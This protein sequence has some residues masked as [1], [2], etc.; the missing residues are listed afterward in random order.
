[1]KN[2]NIC[3]NATKASNSIEE[4]QNLHTHLMEYLK[5]IGDD[6]SN[7][8]LEIFNEAHKFSSEHL[9]KTEPVESKKKQQNGRAR[10]KKSSCLIDEEEIAEK[11]CSMKTASDVLKRIIW[12]DEI[13][14]EFV[15]VGYLDRFLGLKECAFNIFD[16]G[17][18][19]EADLGLFLTCLNFRQLNFY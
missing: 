14:K 13:N 16:W 3:V 15:T 1:L 18:I 17:D 19:V 12:D 7:L 9:A 5:K 2:L 10:D 8:F 4:S 11:K 6:D